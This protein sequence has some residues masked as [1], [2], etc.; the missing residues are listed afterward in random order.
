MNPKLRYGVIAALI[1][2]SSGCGSIRMQY[3]ARVEAENGRTGN[4][5]FE[6][7][8]DL[9]SLPVLCGLTAIWF[10]GACWFY[11]AHPTVPNSNAVRDDAMAKLDEIFGEVPYKLSS[12]KSDKTSWSNMPE[13]S[14]FSEITPASGVVSGK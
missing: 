10:G 6:K 2:I 7:S 12:V 8:Y 13:E 1:F 14:K 11:L 3:G 4:F 9:G 5:V